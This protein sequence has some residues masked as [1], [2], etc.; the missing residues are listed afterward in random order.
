MHFLKILVFFFLLA[1]CK[2]PQTIT[3]TNEV[4]GAELVPVGRFDK[5]N[6]SLELISSGV[7]F[8]FRF[9]GNEC[10]V[11]TSLAS[12]QSSAYLQYEVNGEYQKRIKI[13]N[14][15]NEAF[16]IKAKAK[17]LHTVTIYKTTEAHS[18]PI[19]I[20]KI[21]GQNIQIV[22][23]QKIPLIEF[24]GNSIT[25]GAAADASVVAC[26][27]GEY[28]DRHNAYFAYGPRVARALHA[29][30]LLSSVSGI[31]MYRNWNSDTPTMPQV[32]ERTDLLNYNRSWDFSK[33]TPKI[34]S[35]ALGTNDFSN[36]DGKTPR[37][38]FNSNE[39]INQY[40]SFVKKIK[41][42][43]PQAKIILLG[44]PMVDGEKKVVFQNCLNAV[45]RSI[46]AA[47]PKDF[48]VTVFYPKA[49]NPR[50]CDGHPSV[51]DHQI[52]AEELIPVFRKLIH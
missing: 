8:S 4:T 28:H 14:K 45:K 27:K 13:E 34:I 35:I 41:S 31:G 44:S 1:G 23:P 10:T 42:K 40:I 52:I 22:Q 3:H 16:T 33:F 17:G 9:W 38:P 43:C 30:F 39:F 19:F 50:G 36:G 25:C 11:F 15:I 51:E 32:Y 18:G 49:M 26:G 48:P 20:N 2:T 6:F 12:W 46:D 5:N 24:I 7:H 29:D 37:Q 47:F 21:S